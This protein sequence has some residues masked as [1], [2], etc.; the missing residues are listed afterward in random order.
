MNYRIKIYNKVISLSALVLLVLLVACSKDNKQ[1]TPSNS[2]NNYINLKLD[3]TSYTAVI[4]FGQ[5]FD[6]VNYYSL[7]DKTIQGILK[8]QILQSTISIDS[9]FKKVLGFLNE[10]QLYVGSTTCSDCKSSTTKIDTVKTTCTITRNDNFIGGIIQGTMSGRVTYSS[11]QVD[12]CCRIKNFTGEFK[13][14][15]RK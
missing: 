14:L 13:L 8:G 12:N 6:S 3:T 11:F 15:I 1:N 2:K 4:P 7:S 10:F 9:T 5:K